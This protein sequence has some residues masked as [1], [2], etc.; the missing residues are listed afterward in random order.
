MREHPLAAAIVARAHERKL[1]LASTSTFASIPG[2]GVTGTL[3][4]KTVVLGNRAMMD[5]LGIEVATAIE[6][7]VTRLPLGLSSN[8]RRD[9]LTDLFRLE[10]L[11][12]LRVLNVLEE[13]SCRGCECTAGQKHH[14]CRLIGE[15]AC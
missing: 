14:A 9:Q 13:R 1:A 10:R 2:K 12:D 11:A 7:S 6:R 8:H 3:D 15:C 5:Q 4:G